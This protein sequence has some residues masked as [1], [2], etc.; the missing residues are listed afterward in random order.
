MFPQRQ[1]TL[2]FHSFTSNR[3]GD[4]PSK[5]RIE[6]DIYLRNET[7]ENERT[8]ERTNERNLGVL[9]RVFNSLFAVCPI[10]FERRKGGFSFSCTVD[11]LGTRRAAATHFVIAEI[12]VGPAQT[13][14]KMDCV[15]V[16]LLGINRNFYSFR[17]H[18]FIPTKHANFFVSQNRDRIE[19]TE[20]KRRKGKEGEKRGKE[21]RN[22]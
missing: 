6:M 7:L 4:E 5:P 12:A 17:P 2:S 20:K 10:S 19:N 1:F 15:T 11:E 9:M 21:K 18:F 16:S 3:L 22:T 13:C 8:N 14:Y